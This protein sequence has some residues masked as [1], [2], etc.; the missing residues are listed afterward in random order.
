MKDNGIISIVIAVIVGVLMLSVIFS[1]VNDK[2]Q[3]FS[4]EQ[5][6]INYSTALSEFALTKPSDFGAIT[7]TTSITNT[8]TDLTTLCNLT[9]ISSAPYLRCSEVNILAGGFVNV[10]YGYTK[11]DYYSGTTTRTI[12]NLFGVIFAIGILAII[13]F[14]F[15]GLKK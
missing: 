15:M 12:A 2:T 11:T 7:T 3:T 13:G 9:T 4:A 10:S 14:S 5:K 6:T 8:T 1:G